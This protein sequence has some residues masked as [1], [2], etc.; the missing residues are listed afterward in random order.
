MYIYTIAIAALTQKNANIS[1]QSL[2]LSCA[3]ISMD[4]YLAIY[5]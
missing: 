5:S 3:M 2:K 4:P 1:F